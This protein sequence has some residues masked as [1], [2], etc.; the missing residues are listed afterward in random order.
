MPTTTAPSPFV[1]QRFAPKS[2][3]PIVAHLD[4]AEPGSIVR[5]GLVDEVTE[6][7]HDGIVKAKQVKKGMVVR[8]YLHGAPRGGERIVESVEVLDGGAT[9][10]VTFSSKHSTADYKAAYRFYVKALVGT[11]IRRTRKVPALVPYQEV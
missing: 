2:P 9:V 6:V 1:M 8:A 10:R 11:T 7:E 5:P 4:P 3:E